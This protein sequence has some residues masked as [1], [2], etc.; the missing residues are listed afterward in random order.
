LDAVT[1]KLAR[2]QALKQR[3]L[4]KAESENA[5][6]LHLRKMVFPAE[7]HL[8]S[9]TWDIAFG[10]FIVN[11]AIRRAYQAAAED[12]RALS[13]PVTPKA[14][15]M[16]MASFILQPGWGSRELK[17]GSLDAEERFVYDLMTKG[18]VPAKA[19]A[20]AAEEMWHEAIKEAPE[21]QGGFL[22]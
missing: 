7:E 18:P 19:A 6:H 16:S 2:Q 1:A 14:M 21:Q 3:L 12:G 9:Y 4:D 17:L 11:A 5:K 20:H 13:N 22:G 8:D 10:D 15:V